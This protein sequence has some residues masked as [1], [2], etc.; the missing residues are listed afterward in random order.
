MQHTKEF[1]INGAWITPNSIN[2]LDVINPATEQ[3]VES[4]IMGSTMDVDN[5]VNAA[6]SAFS[7]FSQTSIDE[8]ILL[9]EKIITCYEARWADMALAIMTEM[10]APQRWAKEAQTGSGFGHFTATLAALK[11]YKFEEVIGNT[12]ICKEPIGV[13]AMITPWNWPIN[14]IACK[15]APAIATGC[16][17]VLKP[18]EEAPLSAIIL[19]EILHEAG[20]PKGVFNL[21]QG[22]GITVG[23]ALSSHPDIDMI[24]FTGSTRAGILVSTAAAPTIKR[25]ALELGGKSANILLDDVDFSATVTRDIFNIMSNTGQSCNAPTRMLVPNNRMDEVILIAKAA[26]AQIKPGDPLAEGTII[27][28]VISDIQWHKIQEL[29]KKGIDEGATLV[30]GGLGKPEGLETGYYVKPTIFANVTNEMT[31]ATEEIFGPVLSIIGYKDEDEAVIIANDSQY[32]LSGYVSSKDSNR[33]RNIARRLRTGMVHINGAPVDINAPFGG[34]K[35]SGNG[36]EWGVRGI[37][38][39]LETKSIMGYNE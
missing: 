8:R 36:R 23:K 39:Y 13:C 2:K 32:G 27:G 21:I 30:A 5:A 12:L 26:T 19:A 18:S 16:T 35:Q 22:D 38:D 37:E 15:V 33:A 31:I 25:V 9:L 29:I 10:G 3:A 4:I 6:K 17:I 7:H 20:V 28:P 34:Y 11:E 1:Y 24:S 14:Q